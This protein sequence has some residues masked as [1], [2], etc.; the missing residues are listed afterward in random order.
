M[1]GDRFLF[2]TWV[3][4]P[5]MLVLSSFLYTSWPF[6][7]IRVFVQSYTL[8]LPT[9][10]FQNEGMMQTFPDI[11]KL[12]WGFTIATLIHTKQ[13]MN[14]QSVFVNHLSGR[15]LIFRIYKERK[16]LDGK[17]TSQ[18]KV[19]KDFSSVASKV[20]TLFKG[21]IAICWPV[22]LQLASRWASA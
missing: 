8:Y 22:S 13:Y 4:F 18:T 9:L 12:L 14:W 11:W 3:L 5:R 19:S 10:S 16:L 20:V 21:I 2:W 15:E 6:A 17:K 7:C 1:C